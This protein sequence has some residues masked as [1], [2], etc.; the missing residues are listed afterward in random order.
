MHA[1]DQKNQESE[2][3]TLSRVLGTLSYLQKSIDPTQ[4]TNFST[5]HEVLHN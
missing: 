5:N 3:N 1:Y 4:P 2:L